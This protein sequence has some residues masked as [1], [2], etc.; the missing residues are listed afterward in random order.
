[1][2]ALA[3]FEGVVGVK[4]TIQPVASFLL[5]LYVNGRMQKHVRITEAA[6]ELRGHLLN[7]CLIWGSE[8]G[9]NI[10]GDLNYKYK[11]YRYI[12]ITHFFVYTL[13]VEGAKKFDEQHWVRLGLLTPEEAELLQ[14]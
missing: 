7:I 5:A 4:S 13:I 1:M 10:K 11:L 2:G 9:N 8:I 12:T 14:T 3:V 6:W